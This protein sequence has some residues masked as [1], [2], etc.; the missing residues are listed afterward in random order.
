[1][2]SERILFYI[3]LISK[4]IN[5]NIFTTM[6]KR[7]KMYMLPSMQVLEMQACQLLAGSDGTSSNPE[8]GSF[9]NGSSL[10]GGNMTPSSARSF[11]VWN[12][13]EY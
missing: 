4:E 11:S 10:G 2:L 1:M 12:E 6:D 8:V 3:T 9:G 5:K 13:D 7:K